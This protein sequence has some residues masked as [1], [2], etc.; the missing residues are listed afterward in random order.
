MIV[1]GLEVASSFNFP[2]LKKSHVLSVFLPVHVVVTVPPCDRI[3]DEKN[4][5]LPLLTDTLNF[6]DYRSLPCV[7]YTQPCTNNRTA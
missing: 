6:F 2:V 7:V 5:F 4:N 1:L 3:Q